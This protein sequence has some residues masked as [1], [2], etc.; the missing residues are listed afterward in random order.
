MV[1]K[2]FKSIFAVATILGSAL[3]F[4]AC[5]EK[6][7]RVETLVARRIIAADVKP[8]DTLTVDVRDGGLVVE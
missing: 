1:N 4:V 3:G 2:L 8:G 5:E 7:A 6:G